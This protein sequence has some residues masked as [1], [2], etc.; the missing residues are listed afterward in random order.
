MMNGLFVINPKKIVED[1]AFIIVLVISF[2]WAYW[3]IR[4]GIDDDVFTNFIYGVSIII[5]D[6]LVIIF[7]YVFKAP[8]WSWK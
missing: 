2:I 1:I 3:F 6:V 7:V 8:I 4:T 5:Y